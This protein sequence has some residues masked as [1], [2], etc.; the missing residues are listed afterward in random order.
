MQS[1]EAISNQQIIKIPRFTE[2]YFQTE[3]L[4][5][6]YLEFFFSESRFLIDPDFNILET[7][8]ARMEEREKAES[9]I[10]SH[11]K[12]LEQLKHYIIYQLALYS[13]LLESNSYYISLN[14]HTVI[15]R[16][17]AIPDHPADY[18]LKLYT[19]EEKDLPDNYKDKIYIGRDFISLDKLDRDHF[20]L[21]H[22]RNSLKEQESKIQERFEKFV[23]RPEE[24]EY[25]QQEYLNEIHELL[26]DFYDLAE[27]IMEST[28]VLIRT[29]S[30]KPDELTRINRQYRELKHILIELED[31]VRE[32]E[33]YMFEQVISKAVRYATKFKKDL[34]NYIN[35]LM[36]KVNGRISDAVNGTHI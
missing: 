26:N 30:S 16:L 8:P 24:L 15:C 21:K 35:Y 34:T 18:E 17:L 33:S 29:A 9:L 27:T 20:G 19:I 1:L 31:T 3:L 25:L 2:D 13:S 7:G 28:P 36:L 5:G 12:K 14:N 4:K 10:H 23:I 32:M 6:L 22:I 11:R